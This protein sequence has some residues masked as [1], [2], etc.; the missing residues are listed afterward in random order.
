MSP[1]MDKVG[2]EIGQFDDAGSNGDNNMS[3]VAIDSW[4]V[5]CEGVI[6]V[7]FSKKYDIGIKNSFAGRG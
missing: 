5:V 1:P 4:Q 6:W 7:K 3:I 2:I